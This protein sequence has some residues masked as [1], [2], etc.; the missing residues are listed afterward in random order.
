[1]EELQFDLEEVLDD[2]KHLRELDDDTLDK[3]KLDRH[4]STLEKT[5]EKLNTL[6]C[7]LV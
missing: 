2:L 6:S 5:L 7:S 1:M 4:I 3:K